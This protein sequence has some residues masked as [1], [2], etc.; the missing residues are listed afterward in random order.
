MKKVFALIISCGIIF[1]LLPMVINGVTNNS[2]M[3]S[4][5]DLLI[6]AWVGTQPSE[7]NIKEFQQL[8]QRKLDIVHSF[9]NWSTDFSFVRPMAEAASANGSVLM[10]TWEPWEYN[11]VD[12]NNGK[13]DAYIT[14]M[15]NDIKSFGKEIWLRPLHESNGDWY[16]W[17]I[18]YTS[19]VNTSETVKAAFKHIVDIFRAQGVSN[20][21][22]V[23][24]VNCSNVGS[25]ST[26]MA[27]YPGDEYVDYVSIDGYNWGTTQSWGSRWQSFDEI[28]ADA[29]SAIKSTNKKVIIAEWA[30]TEVGGD[31]PTWITQSFNKIR[32]SY[33][34]VFAVVWFNQNKETDWRI[35][36]SQA[37]LDA[38]V[39]AIAGDS[40]EQDYIVGDVNNDKSINSFDFAELKKFLLG[41]D[42]VV[43]SKSKTADVNS[44]G[45]VNSIDFGLL[46]QYLL[47][48]IKSF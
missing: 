26:Y 40:Q 30:A 12:I 6:G 31:K 36:S 2:L 10:V 39:K 48:M 9:I 18:G 27:H 41:M 19:G 1:S 14:R 44:D 21:K 17:G 23:Y 25:G 8:Q 43:T 7:S 28:F 15:A 46:K 37:A 4:G 42:S 13:A 32:S 45:S 5:N 47:G 34:N 22:W 11:S 33:G 16:P 29:Y 20:V 35:N 24:N 3:A 38:Y